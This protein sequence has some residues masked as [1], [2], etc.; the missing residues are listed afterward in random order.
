MKRVRIAAD[1]ESG[2][3]PQIKVLKTQGADYQRFLATQLKLD[4]TYKDICDIELPTQ[5]QTP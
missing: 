2:E 5:I 1:L 4:G 3:A